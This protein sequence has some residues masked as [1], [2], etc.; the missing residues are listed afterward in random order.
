MKKLFRSERD[1]RVAG[2][3]GGVGEYLDIDP[4]F[5]RVIFI[6]ILV[7]SGFLP[8]TVVYLLAVL[9]IPRHPRISKPNALH[10]D[11]QAHDL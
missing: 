2:V 7:F 4:T 6:F 3:I 11:A 9:V 8:A 1:R 5:L 10:F